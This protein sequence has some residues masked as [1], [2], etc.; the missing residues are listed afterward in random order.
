MVY[1][2]DCKLN[3]APLHARGL[4]NSSIPPLPF[5]FSPKLR[6]FVAGPSGLLGA[7][8]GL[9]YAVI[10]SGAAVLGFQVRIDLERLIKS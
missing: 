4:Y 6:V 5:P 1:A 9:S 3:P 8:E 7:V 10:V 2:F